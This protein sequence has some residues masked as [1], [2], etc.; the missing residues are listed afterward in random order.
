MIYGIT[1]AKL[2]LPDYHKALRQHADY[3]DALR[4]CGLKIEVLPE[5][6]AFPDS[7]FIEDVALCTPSCAIVTNPGAP[8]RNPER[9]LML[10]V[11]EKYYDAIAEIHFPGTL[12]AG[13]VMMVGDTYYIGL[14]ERTDREGAAQLIAILEQHNMVGHMVPLK[15]VLHLKTGISYIEHNNLLVSGEFVG[16]EMLQG[17]NQIVVD[18]DEAYAANSLWVN[19]RVLVPGSCPKTQA[20]IA[21]LGYEVISLDV[22]EFEKVDGGLSC[23]SLRF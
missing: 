15:T 5:H 4:D 22:T 1:T 8:S 19:D 20:K 7:V 23:L 12:D 18:P 3:A 16:A 6:D 13:D 2:G 14:S 9:E 10:P 11:L 21:A 17:Y